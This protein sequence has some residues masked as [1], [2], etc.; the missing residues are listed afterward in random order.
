MTE[1]YIYQ[2]ERELL[3]YFRNNIT[4][5]EDRGIDTTDT[6]TATA[7]QTV[8]TLKNNLVKNVA[9]TIT[10]NSV[11]KYKGSDYTVTYGEG[12]K[13]TIVTLKTAATLGWAVVIGYHYGES[14]IEREYS[15]TDVK[16]PRIV[17]MFLTGSEAFAALGDYVESTLGSYFNV[18]Y[19]LEI[20][21]KYATQA[22][23]LASE[24]FNLCR[25]M[26]HS[27]LYRTNITRP[28]AMMNFDYDREKEAY[29]WQFTVDIQW[30][31]MFQ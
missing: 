13:P 11:T 17:I 21:S 27:G 5:P 6:F 12:K 4:D 15:R 29:I 10:V 2:R 25:K 30:E 31:I 16:L 20:R 19:R 28:N 18:S 1:E 23:Q 24:A 7:L 22:R 26:R 14:M 8:F 9:D 3:D